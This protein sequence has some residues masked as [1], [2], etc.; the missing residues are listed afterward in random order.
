MS[1]EL[2]MRTAP[3]LSETQWLVWALV[4]GLLV[5]LAWWLQRRARAQPS[6]GVSQQR[7]ALGQ[8]CY[9][10][11]LTVGQRQ[12]RIYQAGASMVLLPNDGHDLVSSQEAADGSR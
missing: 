4:C 1:S 10:V 8:G 12:Y 11:E 9:L 5:L 7:T 2:G 6:H 3:L